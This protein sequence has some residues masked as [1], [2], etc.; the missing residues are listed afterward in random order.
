LYNRGVAKFRMQDTLSACADWSAAA[1]YGDTSVYPVILKYCHGLIVFDGDTVTVQQSRMK[2]TSRVYEIVEVMPQFPGGE[3]ALMRFI[4][5]NIKYPDDAK[6][7]RMQGRVY[8]TFVVGKSGAIEE[9]SILKGTGNSLEGE[10]LRVINRMPPWN[11][12]MQNGK[13][14]RV[15]YNLPINFQLK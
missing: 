8:V 12:G 9:A 1:Y 3:Q 14:V 2:D 6:S 13:P 10:A 7:N 11:P 4:S 5:E 15:K